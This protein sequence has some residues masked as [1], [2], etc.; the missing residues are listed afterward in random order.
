MPE[1]VLDLNGNPRFVDDPFTPDTGN[2]QPPLVDMGA[3]EF[4][5]PLRAVLD[6]KPGSCPNPL[7]PNPKG[8]GVV[9]MALVGSES[10]D[11]TDVNL[12]TLVLV[13]PDGVG[14]S[15]VPL[16][17]S[18]GQTGTLED[19]AGPAGDDPCACSEAGGDGIDDLVLKFSSPELVRAFQLDSLRRSASL[20]IALR[21]R[22][23][24][25]TEFAALDCVR[26]VGP[27]IIRVPEPNRAV[28]AN[29]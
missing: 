2:G 9:P 12:D 23:F 3:Y 29:P 11:V 16:T 7:N 10:F 1:T 15:V 8:K 17:R 6:I 24:D 13:R 22:L 14:E 28:P 19:V 27:A 21:G 26:I 5:E 25:G 4:Q 18:R 20:T